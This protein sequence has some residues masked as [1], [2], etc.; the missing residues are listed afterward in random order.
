[1]RLRPRQRQRQRPRRRLMGT[2]M[3]VTLPLLLGL[4]AP[5]SGPAFATGTGT[6][7]AA[8]SDSATAVFG[9]A[10]ETGRATVDAS[11]GSDEPSANVRTYGD[12]DCWEIGPGRPNQYL[13]VTLDT[14]LKHDGK[15]FAG[16]D[17]EYFDGPDAKFALVY[18]AVSNPWRTSRIINTTGTN[19][20]KT[21]HFYL[22]DGAFTGGQHGR[23]MRIATW[24][25][26]MGSSGRPVCF[27]RYALTPSPVDTDDVQVE[28]TTPG[29][30]FDPGE[31]ATFGVLATRDRTVPWSVR[32]YRGRTVGGGRAAIDP[33][34]GRG[35]VDVGE[36]PL[37]YYT[38][39]LRGSAADGA[40]VSRT[41]GFA[42]QHPGPDPRR[43]TDSFFGVNHHHRSAPDDAW[44]DSTA[45]AARAGIDALRVD[46]AYWGS[47]E[48]PKGT[49]QWP[50]ATERVTA[51]FGTRGQNGLMLLG[52]GN[53]DYGGIPST[54]EAYEAFGRYSGKV[55]EQAG[56]RIESLEVWNEYYGGFSSGVCSQS[57]KC[58]AKLLAAAYPAVKAADPKITLVGASSFKVPLDWF[59]ELFSLGA[60]KHMDAVSIHPYR[61]PGAPEGV[62]LDIAGLKRLMRQYN[63]GKELPVWITEQGWTS[64][65]RD[66]IG[67]SEQTQAQATAR[68][69]LEAKAAGV[70]RYYWYDLINDGNGPS[71]GEQNFGLLRRSGPEAT[72][73]N[74][75]PAYLAYATAARELTG[76]TFTGRLRTGDAGLHAYR[77]A[78]APGSPG[79][80]STTTVL[81]SS[82]RTGEPVRIRATKPV[83][84]VDM[85][86]G[87]RVLEPVGGWVHLTATG[88]PLYL[89]APVSRI[90]KSPLLSLSTPRDI[91]AGADVPVTAT[92][93]NRAAGGHGS[94]SA[95]RT[96]VFEVEGERVTVTAAPGRRASAVLKVP[97]GA[98]PGSRVL[99]ASVTVDG[100]RAGALAAGT[101]VV[102]E[103]VTVDVSPDMSVAH[104]S[105]TDRLAVTVTNHS[106]DR[107]V[108]VTGID[109]SFGDRSGRIEGAGSGS[110]EAGSGGNRS[111][112]SAGGGSD[113]HRVPPL[114]SRT[115]RT[116]VDGAS[117]YAVQPVAVTA[118]LADGRTARDSD[119][120]GFS[121]VTRATP[122]LVGG[123]LTGLRGVPKVDLSEVGSYKGIDASAA[124]G[125]MWATWDD[126]NLYVSAVV[127]EKDYRAPEKVAWLPAGDS[128]GIGVQPGKPGDGLGRW[129]A[130]WYM[131][132]AGDTTRE[133]PGVFVES[134]PKDYPV[135][136]VDGADVRVSRDAAAGTTT[137]LVAVPWKRIAPLSPAD[138]SF[139]L[140]LTVNKN[141]GVQRDKYR[142]LGLRGWQTW[143]DGLNN[144]KLVRYQQVRLT[145]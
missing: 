32:D 87:E 39:T 62:G 107:P 31:K 109:W 85:L 141:D 105:R 25:Q 69:L 79:A 126:K 27:A 60:L 114:G 35:S 20:W 42:V 93:D 108:T 47:I 102:A 111:T 40:P 7:G 77:F 50:A 136:A 83:T 103:P 115:F 2:A 17:I 19:V 139:S 118:R 124:D 140:T 125:D 61:A 43:T 6:G 71:N 130:D 133:G 135:G 16:V 88:D 98:T 68:A 70:A 90:E 99:A 26:D 84:V 75:K 89:R 127:R 122:R 14:G 66:G 144:W 36:L 41:A 73:L 51:D 10:L 113:R 18:D 4:L 24:A 123:E 1:M 49:Y 55:A 80:G 3:A 101:E 97:A 74:P 78:S 96:A 128:I 104:G 33:T 57:A 95:R 86:G 138:P 34:T 13:N 76:A 134:L 110:A 45:L 37:G 46:S 30:L 67:V 81:W 52:L 112:G 56:G 116:E 64:A 72:G 63:D 48:R 21:A 38:L 94:T 59:E 11:P 53:G 131:L 58:Y 54:P 106:P 142:S 119:S 28:V 143:G 137:Y 91:V 12:R 22:P 117:A 129:G 145:R 23:D 120:F 8:A 82:D 44:D 5:G 29:N 92:V 9:R 132:Y 15:N 100:K 65:D 121:P